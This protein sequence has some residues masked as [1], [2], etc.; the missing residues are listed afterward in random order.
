MKEKNIEFKFHYYSL[1]N[2][3]RSD[4]NRLKCLLLIF[5]NNAIKYTSNGNIQIYVNDHFDSN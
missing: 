1:N 2:K 3:I 5:I 4:V